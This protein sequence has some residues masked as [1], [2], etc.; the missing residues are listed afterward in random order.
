MT[1]AWQAQQAAT[2]VLAAMRIQVAQENAESPDV[3]NLGPLS[4]IGPNAHDGGGD[5][6]SW[7]E[8][9]RRQ[10][11]QNLHIGHALHQHAERAEVLRSRPRRQLHAN[12]PLRRDH[13]ALEGRSEERR[14]GKEWRSRWSPYHLIKNEEYSDK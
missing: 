4:G 6:R 12:F 2:Q 10:P 3:A 8:H 14:V 9:G 7:P 1:H 13:H 5:L 11:A